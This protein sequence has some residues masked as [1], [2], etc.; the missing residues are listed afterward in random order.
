MSPF[1]HAD[2]YR[3]YI[4]Y[5]VCLFC[6]RAAIDTAPR[7]YQ[8]HIRVIIILIQCTERHLIIAA[9]TLIYFAASIISAGSPSSFAAFDIVPLATDTCL[10]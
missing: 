2:A 7:M 8:Q 10:F 3:F 6:E 5:Y 1:F 9:I 4:R